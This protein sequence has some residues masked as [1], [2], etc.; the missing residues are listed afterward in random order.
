M[1]GGAEPVSPADRLVWLAWER[2]PDGSLHVLETHE[3]DGG[4][5]ERRTREFESVDQA[6][7]AYGE[8]FGELV[9]EVLESGST[10]GRYRP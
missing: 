7:G 2:R 1:P 3:S 4:E 9:E 8:R 10:R 6:A 5:Y